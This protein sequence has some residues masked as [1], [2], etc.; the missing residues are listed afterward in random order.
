M[1]IHKQN[2]EMMIA[3]RRA[4]KAVS[5][6]EDVEEYK[7]RMASTNTAGTEREKLFD[8]KMV[9]AVHTWM[10]EAVKEKVA[11]FKNFMSPKRSQEELLQGRGAGSPIM[12]GM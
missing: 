5:F 8:E 9:R 3:P 4:V 1:K 2:F 12:N 11:M 6:E 10:E 7:V